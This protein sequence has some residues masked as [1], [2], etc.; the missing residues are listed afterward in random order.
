[1]TLSMSSPVRYIQQQTNTALSIQPGSLWVGG[2][3]NGLGAFSRAARCD[4]CHPLLL[5]T[6]LCVNPCLVKNERSSRCQAS[7]GT[8]TIE[9]R[10]TLS[11]SSHFLSKN[12][13]TSRCQASF[14]TLKI[15]KRTTLSMSSPFR[16]IQ[17]PTNPSRNEPHLPS[18]GWPVTPP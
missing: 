12:E 17:Q 4:T 18:L 5:S 16:Y 14:G 11:M 8:S 1:M 2:S 7:L 6:P 15:E 13:R 3:K 10:T 9:K